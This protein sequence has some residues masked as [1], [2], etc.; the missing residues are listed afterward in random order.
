MLTGSVEEAALFPEGENA[1]EGQS[2]EGVADSG[3][4]R[5]HAVPECQHA[6]G[7]ENHQRA[8]GRLAIW[9]QPE[10][11]GRDLFRAPDQFVR[12]AF[13]EHEAQAFLDIG[14]K[15]HGSVGPDGI[16]MQ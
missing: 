10:R 11:R 9:H 12:P 4:S 5:V 14:E 1:H 3:R 13:H 8:S 16:G 15:A 6:S 2:A 7:A